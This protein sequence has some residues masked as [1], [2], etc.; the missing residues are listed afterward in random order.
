MYAFLDTETTGFARG[1]VQPR[2]VSIAWMIA[3]EPGR[4]RVFKRRVVRPDGFSIP[5]GAAAVHGITTA[6]ARAEGRPISAVLAD[7]AR[8]LR[9]LRPEALVAHNARYDLPVVAA[10][11]ERLGADDPCRGTRTVCTMLQCRDVWPGESAK[12]G[13]V[14]LRVFGE[15]LRDAHDAGA[16]VRACARIFFHLASKRDRAASSHAKPE[17]IRVGAAAADTD[18]GGHADW[19]SMVQAV[20]EWAA[21]KARFD[22][23]FVESLQERLALGYELTPGQ[24]A[25]L[26]NI[27]TKCSIPV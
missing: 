1:G 10:E 23:A 18:H 16:D 8:D 27:I 26:R 9:T 19:H 3:A 22:T 2:I 12:L 25:A 14:H 5:A 7:F 6:R 17:P 21:C 20:L 4:P 15:A 13:D 24:K 11:F